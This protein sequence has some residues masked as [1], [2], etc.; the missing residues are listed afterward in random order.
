ME[1]PASLGKIICN[2]IGI[3]VVTFIA[4][5]LLKSGI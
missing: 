4:S 1:E 3:A 5:I 2:A